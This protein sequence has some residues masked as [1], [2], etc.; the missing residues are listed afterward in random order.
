A[1]EIQEKN[2][3]IGHIKI[4][5]TLNNIGHVLMN[6]M[7]YDESLDYYKQAHLILVKFKSNYPL[8][9]LQIAFNLS[10]ISDILHLQKKYQTRKCPKTPP[11]GNP[12]REIC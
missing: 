10:Y 3:P 9:Q 5:T 8:N 7:K 1:L 11:K 6:Q 12:A 2:Y 4:A